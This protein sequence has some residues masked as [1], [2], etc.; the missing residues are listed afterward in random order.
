MITRTLIAPPERMN[1]EVD[2]PVVHE[3]QPVKMAVGTMEQVVS[4]MV[5][6]QQL[7]LDAD[8]NELLDLRR[9]VTVQI[10]GTAVD[11]QWSAFLAEA[12]TQQDID[13]LHQF[14]LDSEPSKAN[15][16]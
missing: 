2:P 16:I 15:M 6:A 13:D 4:G 5:M 7:V 1:Y 11:S 8:N 14:I 3:I 12:A 9:N 10:S